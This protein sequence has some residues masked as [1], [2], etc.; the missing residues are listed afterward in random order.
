M[1]T[2]PTEIDTSKKST[3]RSGATIKKAFFP[4]NT[5]E[6]SQVCMYLEDKK[7]VILGGISNCLILEDIPFAI[8]LTNM[9]GI[10]MEDKYLIASAGEN[11]SH[12]SHFVGLLGLSGLENLIGIPGTLGGAVY[13]NSGSFGV[14]ISDFV[15]SVKIYNRKTNEFEEYKRSE[16]GFFD[17]N[18]TFIKDWDIITSVKLE[19]PTKSPAE[20]TERM[21]EVISKRKNSQPNYASLGSVFR[22]YDNISAG[23][24]IEKA[25][26]KG[27]KIGDMQVSEKHANFIIN[28]NKGTTKDYYNLMCFVENEVYQQLGIKLVRE[29]RVIGKHENL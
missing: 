28:T 25:G 10:E 26:L 20:I 12:L 19:F 3:L 1:L 7:P 5:Q 18:T 13:G 24:F 4:T 6:L 27:K 11:L 23:Y 22:K 15:Y 2:Q 17:R 8:I 16:I 21:D 9:R 14:N 29:V